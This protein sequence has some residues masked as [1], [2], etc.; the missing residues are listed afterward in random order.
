[1]DTVEFVTAFSL[2]ETTTTTKNDLLNTYIYENLTQV[3]VSGSLKVLEIYFIIA[4]T[5]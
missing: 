5:Y 1:M 4:G 2:H 3:L